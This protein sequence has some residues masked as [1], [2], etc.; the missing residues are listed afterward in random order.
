MKI[1]AYQFPVS[2]NMEENASHIESAIHQAHN[3]G[4]QLLVF[5]ECAMTG[6]PPHCIKSS[7]DVDFDLLDRMFQRVQ[8]LSVQDSMYIILGSITKKETGYYNSALVFEPG[9]GIGSYDKR[10][11][12][13]WDR[14]NFSQGQ[15]PGVFEIGQMKVGIRICFEVRFPEFFR[16]LYK[17]STTL[18]VILFYDT[19]N[20][21]NDSRYALIKGHIQTRAVENVCSIL[22]VNAASPYQTAP[23]AL[24]GCS[25][26]M[27]CELTPGKEGLLLYDFQ[28]SPLNFGELGRKEITDSLLP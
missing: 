4:I 27:L 10:A 22:S 26:E 23:T 15:S 12:W 5:P 24:F 6:Y 14:D 8:A 11:L 25:G 21:P 7:S 28:P 18:N 20:Q 9:G 19:S 2:G 17:E 13:G 3:A 1:G 16:E